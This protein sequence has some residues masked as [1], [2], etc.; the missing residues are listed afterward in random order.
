MVVGVDGAFPASRTAEQLVGTARDYLVGVHVG[1]RA[2]AGLPHDEREMIVE[3]SFG[4]LAS[5]RDDRFGQPRIEQAQPG[6]DPCRRLLDPA[7]RM[8][9]RQGHAIIADAKVFERALRLRAPQPVGGDFDSAHRVMLGAG[10]VHSGA[11]AHQGSS[12]LGR[13]AVPSQA[14]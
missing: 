6:V 2:R 8:D 14:G 13:V 3:L 12:R 7:Q 5:R 10:S 1:L 9:E 4:H 11:P